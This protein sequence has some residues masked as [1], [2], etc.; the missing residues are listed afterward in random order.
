MINPLDL[1]NLTFVKFF[2]TNFLIQANLYGSDFCKILA[3]L[4][5][6]NGLSYVS[7]FLWYQ[8]LSYSYA[9]F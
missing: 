9:P 8:S 6:N 4:I 1:Q 7:R 5:E 3:I 2:K